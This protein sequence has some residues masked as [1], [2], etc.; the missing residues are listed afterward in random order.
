MSTDP[1]AHV[2]APGRRFALGRGG[3]R[4]TRAPSLAISPGGFRLAQLVWLLLG[5]VDAVLAL[6]LLFRGARAHPTQFVQVV[7]V[8][9]AGLSRPFAGTVAGPGPAGAHPADWADLLALLVYT[10][11]AWALV[12]FIVIVAVPWRRRRAGS[13]M[14]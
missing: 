7:E 11:A 13:P 9:A 1:Q 4:R 2:R 3:R 6:D 12:R 5:L 10:V 8:L 14:P